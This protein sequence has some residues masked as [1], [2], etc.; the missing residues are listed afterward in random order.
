M[1]ICEGPSPRGRP[2]R[3]GVSIF[4]PKI[5]FFLKPNIWDLSFSKDGYIVFIVNSFLSFVFSKKNPVCYKNL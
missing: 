1:I 5:V 2:L 3:T 4:F